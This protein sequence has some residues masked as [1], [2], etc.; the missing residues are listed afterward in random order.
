MAARW[1]H[2]RTTTGGH[3]R[4]I[5][6]RRQRRPATPPNPFSNPTYT[7]GFPM[8]EPGPVALPRA[9]GEY[10]EQEPQGAWTRS[11]NVGALARTT[12]RYFYV[13]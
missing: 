10:T 4:Q 7:D 13:L 12:Q 5:M 11:A 3:R 6:A 9:A 8:R 1:H 2:P